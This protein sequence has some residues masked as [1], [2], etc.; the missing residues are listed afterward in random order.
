MNPAN[1][2]AQASFTAGPAALLGGWL[3]MRPIDGDL[4]PGP[5]WTAAHAV[6]LAGFLAF[7]VMTLALRGMAGPVT[8]G[9]RAAVTG[10]VAAALFSVAANVVQLVIDLYAG[11]TAVD[12]EAMRAVFDQVKSYPGVEL[13][14]YSAGAQ[15]FYA[16]LLALAFLLAAL[17]R[18][19][20]VSAVVTASGVLVLA[21]GTFQSGR[22]SALVAVGMALMWLGTLLLGRGS[23]AAPEGTAP[24]AGRQAISRSR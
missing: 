7:G 22:D 1:R 8:G 23:S 21:V 4:V 24:I 9:G 19:T 10:T 18:V 3:L 11:L 12:G 5:W 13:I 15:L 16:A 6:W 2:L 17:R 14:V 20:L